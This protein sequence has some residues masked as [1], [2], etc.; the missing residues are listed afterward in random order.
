MP[1]IATGTGGAAMDVSSELELP[2]SERSAAL[3]F[4][5]S[6]VQMQPPA[7]I[8][9]QSPHTAHH[10]LINRMKAKQSTTIGKCS[11]C[12]ER[13]RPHGVVRVLMDEEITTAKYGKIVGKQTA[14]FREIRLGSIHLREL[15]F[16]VLK[17][18]ILRSNP[19]SIQD[20]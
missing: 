19:F 3:L 1:P 14:L 11:P 17:I 13:P 5:C 18:F 10:G 16:H 15:M 9:H 20:C 12:L 2:A 4:D 7:P 8:H 6:I